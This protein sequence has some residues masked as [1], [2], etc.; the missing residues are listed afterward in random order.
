MCNIFLNIFHIFTTTDI[1]WH[2]TSTRIDIL[3]S[4]TYPSLE[5]NCNPKLILS[6]SNRNNSC[7]LWTQVF[8]SP[9]FNHFE[10]S[11]PFVKLFT[12]FYILKPLTSDLH[13]KTIG[14]VGY[15]H[16]ETIF[17]TSFG[18]YVTNVNTL[19]QYCF[20]IWYITSTRCSHLALWPDMTL[21]QHNKD[22]TQVLLTHYGACT[23]TVYCTLSRKMQSML[24]FSR[25]FL[26]MRCVTYKYT[27]TPSDTVMNIHR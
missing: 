3:Y 4:S 9:L 12:K 11:F 14:W 15:A 1:E 2:L 20:I 19:N 22:R 13:P 17:F 18:G 16:D 23:Y 25:Y 26:N 24:S 6:K 7:S 10:L 27:T 21:H 8:P 5:I